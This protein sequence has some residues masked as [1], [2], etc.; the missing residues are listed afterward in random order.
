M[1]LSV[2]RTTSALSR[3]EV[4]DSSTSE[5][6]FA[7]RPALDGLRAIAVLTVV[8][9][10]SRGGIFPGGYIGVDFFFVLSGY[11]ITSLLVSEHRRAGGVS[12]RRFYAR[13]ALRLLPALLLMCAVVLTAWSLVPSLPDHDETLTGVLTSL[14]YTSSPV[15]AAGGSGLGAMIPTWSLSVEEYFYFLW[16]LLLL[17][18]MTRAGER[19]RIAVGSIALLTIVYRWWAPLG[20]GWDITR[21]AYG[22][23]TRAEQLVIGCSLAVV[24]PRTGRTIRTG[25]AAAA[26]G[27]MIVFVLWPGNETHEAYLYGGS[28]VVALS[29]AL[30][31]A[32]VVQHPTSGVGRALCARPLVWV[33]QRSYGIYL[34][35][36]PLIALVAAAPMPGP[37]QLVTK[38]VL[39]FAIPAIS[40][41]YLEAP[42][43]NFKRRLT[44]AP[45][46]AS[47]ELG[48]VAAVARP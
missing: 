32:H 5:R 14:T 11:L 18:L 48:V 10:H 35:H 16:P 13:R 45:A 36:V 2:S 42:C 31:I 23:D 41:K 29:A 25:V 21:I 38:L 30:L 46:P 15:A 44:Q 22:A 26:T 39:V 19:L 33:G 40:Y 7:Y 6:G 20:A 17:A 1:S 8:M 9:F 4:R 3:P 47:S 28:T 34:W 37:T 43:L 24:L 12:F 27:L